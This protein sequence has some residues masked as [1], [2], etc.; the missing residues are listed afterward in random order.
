MFP[1]EFPGIPGEIPPGIFR[2]TV[3]I[4]KETIRIFPRNL[5]G[6]HTFPKRSLTKSPPFFRKSP[7]GNF[8][9]FLTL[10]RRKKF[11]TFSRKN[12]PEVFPSEL[13]QKFP[14]MS[15]KFPDRIFMENVSHIFEKSFANVYP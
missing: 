5:W 4:R 10:R 15:E 12:F 3:G 2:E 13:F 8:G 11:P 7:G 6:K 1:P 9:G 14:E